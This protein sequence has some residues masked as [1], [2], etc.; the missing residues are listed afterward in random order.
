MTIRPARLEEVD[1]LVKLCLSFLQ[2][3]HYYDALARHVTPESLGVLIR[4]LF[5]MGDDACLLVAENRDGVVVGGLG[6]L[7]MPHPFTAQPFADELV[8]WVEPEYRGSLVGPK[9][10][11]A[12]EAWARERGL[13]LLKMV[14]PMVRNEEGK[15]VV[16]EVGRW[17]ERQGYQPCEVSYV[18]EL[19]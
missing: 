4:A 8:W 16:S 19:V 15:L 10:Y 1:D 17:Y 7:A 2:T 9:L 3:T 5:A 11:Q 18:K 13:A 14:A 12:G 6:L